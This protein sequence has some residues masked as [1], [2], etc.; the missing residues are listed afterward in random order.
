V[1]ELQVEAVGMLTRAG[2]RAIRTGAP[3]VAANTFTRAAEVLE[4]LGTP[5]ADLAAAELR[6]RAGAQA[7]SAGELSV[8]RELYDAAA[9][10]Y[11]SQ[12]LT[13]DAA[14]AE[15]SAGA[16]LRRAGRLEEARARITAALAVLEVEPDAD[17]VR[18]LGEMAAAEAFAGNAVDADRLSAQAL[19]E[20]QAL[21]SP[22]AVIADLFVTRG[23]SHGLASRMI[24]AAASFREG[25]R[26]A[27]AAGDSAASA[28]GLLN[29]GDALASVDP[30]SS[31][32]ASRE[33]MKLCRRLGNRYMLGVTIA[34][35]IGALVQV[36]EWDEARA[37]YQAGLI[38][39]DLA[40]DRPFQ[41]GAVQLFGLV[42]DRERTTNAAATLLNGV[43]EDP[44]D[45]A[46][47]SCA[48]AAAAWLDGDFDE[49]LRHAAE[50]IELARGISINAD[51][52]RI[53]WVIAADAALATNDLAEVE[54][55][56][57]WL[58][59]HRPGHVPAVLRAARLRVAAGLLAARGDPGA[60][61]SFEGAVR[62]HRELGSPYHLAVCLLDFAEHLAAIDRPESVTEL[63]DEAG[64]IAA[65][66]GAQRLAART[67]RLRSPVEAAVRSDSRAAPRSAP[68]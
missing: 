39:D 8:A 19:S 26:R 14:R 21:G 4:L 44:Q 24:Q 52:V 18:A 3:N 22:D 54:R 7:S 11:S 59:G 9:A 16:T 43:I 60:T 10:G 20:A 53:G 32:A 17:Y 37:V 42:G 38:D 27:E 46:A 36:G 40:D 45:R 23:I 62:A 56:L 49:A 33:A 41:W 2:E 67:A 47:T 68:A 5:E 51:S 63:L 30:L 57:S 35:L 1:P 31:A 29:L 64:E 65:R 58:S 13:R 50:T 66:L 15:M 12:G 6:E 61:A 48:L 28:R 25:V 55:L 34:N